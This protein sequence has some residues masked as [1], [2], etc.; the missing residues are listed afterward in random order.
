MI[1]PLE[2]PPVGGNTLWADM[3]TAYELR[4]TDIQ[5]RI[6]PLVRA[7]LDQRL[8][9][10]HARRGRRGALGQLGLSA[11]PSRDYHPARRVM[12]RISIVGDRPV[13][14]AA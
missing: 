1:S 4:P 9:P 3:G 11:L 6:D 8:W 13:G 7:R 2:V 10:R 5:E 12:D 14:I